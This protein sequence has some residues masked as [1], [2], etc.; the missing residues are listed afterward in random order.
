MEILIKIKKQLFVKILV[1]VSVLIFLGAFFVLRP[2]FG[3]K[4]TRVSYTTQNNTSI[5]RINLNFEIH[6]QKGFV[7]KEGNVTVKYTTDQGTFEDI[8]DVEYY[9]VQK[10]YYGNYSI[11]N[12]EIKVNSYRVT[13]YAKYVV[14]AVIMFLISGAGIVY[15]IYY[16]THNR[17]IK[18]DGEQ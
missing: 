7:F 6:T 11:F 9:K 18:I 14:P 12:V 13:G 2:T 5:G 15:C 8:L 10:F 3:N 1:I 17:N 4:I 16:W